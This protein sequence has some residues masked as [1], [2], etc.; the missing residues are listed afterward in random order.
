[1]NHLKHTHYPTTNDS[2]EAIVDDRTTPTA[3]LIHYIYAV[4]FNKTSSDT[5]LV[6]TVVNVASAGEN[7]K[8]LKT[9]LN[10]DTKTERIMNQ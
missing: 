3:A 2:D 5:L 8:V 6:Q 10:G 1:M 7:V 4:S 9:S